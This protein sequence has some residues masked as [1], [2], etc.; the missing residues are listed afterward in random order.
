MDDGVAST[1]RAI[2]I[3]LARCLH[4]RT[5]RLL[6][7]PVDLE[8]GKIVTGLFA[9]LPGDILQ[10]LHWTDQL[11]PTRFS[12]VGQEIGRDIGGINNVRLRLQVL[13]F[14]VR[15]DRLTHFHILGRRQH[16]FNVSTCVIK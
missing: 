1:V 4:L 15:I 14:Q 2:L 12:G 5:G 9:G 7:V 13:L 3:P 8:L 11:D 6:V 16:H 10:L